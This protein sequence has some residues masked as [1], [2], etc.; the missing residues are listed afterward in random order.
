[1]PHDGRRI[2]RRSA[3]ALLGASAAL[4]R[5]ARA[6]S[7]PQ[8]TVRVIVPY[9]A[10]G[11]TDTMCR[12]ICTQLTSRI[13]QPFVVENRTGAGGAIG[14]EAVARATDGHTLLFAA[15]GVFNALPRMQKLG[16]DPVA[17]LTGISIV[18]VNGML[19]GVR[20]DFPA[21]DLAEFV[22]YAK[23][24]PGE[25]NCG[26]S[27]IGTSSHLAPLMLMV[28][29]GIDIVMVPYPSVPAAI[30]DVLG[31]RIQVHFGSP[32]DII[33]QMGKGIKVLANSGARRSPQVPDIPTVAETYP[34]GVYE[35]WNGFF[36]P[37]DT[38]QAV[39][40]MLSQHIVAIVKEAEMGQRFAALGIDATGTTP[41]EVVATIAREAP[42]YEASLKAAGLMKN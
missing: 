19:L 16:F 35:A 3:L 37:R 32:A 29:A 36:A 9:G 15:G 34:G 2:A 26:S 4:P 6:Q 7:W 5:P 25:L 24:H 42:V 30:A 10:G 33:P 23:A 31:G 20:E 39:I 38:P 22:A 8:R 11:A 13:G 21:R 40:G 17:D 27:S 28:K 14:A 18:G 12:M 1:M 41:E